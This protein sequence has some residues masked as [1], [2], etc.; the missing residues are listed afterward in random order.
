MGLVPVLAH[1]YI[2]HQGHGQLR[3][4][5]HVSADGIRRRIQHLRAVLQEL[6]ENHGK[7]TKLVQKQ[8]KD[9][10]LYRTIRGGLYVGDQ[11]DFAFYPF[12]DEPE[13]EARYRTWWR[14]AQNPPLRP[15]MEGNCAG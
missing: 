13:L 10:P 1:A 8:V 7:Q 6:S 4:S 9:G 12:P 15:S 11:Q 5:A 2:H 14:S 3:R